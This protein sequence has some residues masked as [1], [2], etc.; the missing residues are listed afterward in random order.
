MLAKLSAERM[1]AHCP[2][3]RLDGA[4][5]LRLRAAGKLELRVADR[6]A[7]RRPARRRSSGRSAQEAE[8][9]RHAGWRARSGFSDLLGRRALDPVRR[10]RALRRLR[11]ARSRRPH[12]RAGRAARTTPE[13][14]HRGRRRRAAARRSRPSR[15][16]QELR[17]LRRAARA[18]S[19]SRRLDLR[20]ALCQE[21][22]LD[23]GRLPFAGELIPVRD[24]RVGLGRRRRAAAARLRPV[25]SWSRTTHYAPSPTGSTAHHL[26]RRVVYYRVPGPPAS[27][28]SATCPAAGDPQ[29]AGRP[30]WTSS[31]HR[32]SPPGW[33][34][35]WRTAPTWPASP[36]MDEF[37]RDARAITRAGQIK[38]TGE[39][40]REGRPAPHR[41]PQPLRARLDQRR[42]DRRAAAAGGRALRA[43]ARPR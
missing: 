20:A 1:A 3:G 41:R 21:L 6:R 12:E 40:A 29:S 2:A 11:R 38:G 15:S 5:E 10:R 7:R 42:Q 37:R 24:A 27:A 32:R 23:E 4:A 43:T 18:T 34:A 14:A 28:R 16:T 19:P 39:P 22:R 26:E 35:S 9:P 30:S 31:R 33:S 8:K 17:S 25:A 36:T 13:R